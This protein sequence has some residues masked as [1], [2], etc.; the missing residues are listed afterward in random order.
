MPALQETDFWDRV[1]FHNVLLGLFSMTAYETSFQSCMK[2]QICRRGFIYGSFSSYI[3]GILEKRVS[4][5]DEGPPECLAHSP[6]LN[7]LY[8]YLRGHL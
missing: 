3:S 7:P 6:D 2:M 5:W 8:C 1:F 4:R